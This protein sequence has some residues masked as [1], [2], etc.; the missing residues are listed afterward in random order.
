VKAET[1]MTPA[2]VKLIFVL[3][4]ATTLY[5]AGVIWVVQLVHYPLFSQVGTENFV[6]YEISHMNRI[7]LVV[8]LPMLIEL[9]TTVLLLFHRPESLSRAL[10]ITGAI[11]VAIIWLSTFI[12]Q[13][14]QHS[15]LAQGF[16]AGTHRA[17]VMTNWIRTIAWSARGVLVLWMTQRIMK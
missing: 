17:L 9:L 2:I 7:T 6:A 5:M 8:A 12:F 1:E 4:V 16:D 10:V 15:H 13:D 14:A 11:L 3:N